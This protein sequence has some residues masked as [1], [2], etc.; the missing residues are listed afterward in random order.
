MML[1][2]SIKPYATNAVG[3]GGFVILGMG[4]SA[5]NVEGVLK[6]DGLGAGWDSVPWW[7]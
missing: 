4:A 2:G 5:V 6:S 3:F 1:M 7:G